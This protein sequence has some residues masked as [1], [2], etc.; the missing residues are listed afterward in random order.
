MGRCA[1]CGEKTGFLKSY[2]DKEELW[3]YGTLLEVVDGFYKGQKG[4]LVA[5]YDCGW[6]TTFDYKIE[7]EN[8][9][10]IDGLDERELKKIK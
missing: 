1:R 9:K 10:I 8:L 7:T 6:K 3:P 5:Y 4:K 2:C